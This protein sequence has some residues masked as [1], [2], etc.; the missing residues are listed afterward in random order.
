M[1]ALITIS[2]DELDK[3]IR[4]SNEE[5]F[6]VR[7][8][9]PHKYAG[10]NR[11]LLLRHTETDTDLDIKIGEVPVLEDLVRRSK[12][13]AIGS[14]QLRIPDKEDLILLMHMSHQKSLDMARKF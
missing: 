4:D 5:G 2:I 3:L 12:I 14:Q 8:D 6:Q 1:D 10:I 9:D 11:L 7:M 13:V